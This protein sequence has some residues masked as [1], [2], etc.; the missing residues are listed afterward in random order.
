[1]YQFSRSIYRELAPDVVEDG[2]DAHANRIA[3]SEV[4]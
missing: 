2:K 4:L 3:L 1:M